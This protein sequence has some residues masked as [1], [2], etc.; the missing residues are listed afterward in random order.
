MEFQ[1]RLQCIWSFPEHAKL[2]D[3]AQP[4]SNYFWKYA[5]ATPYAQEIHA[6]KDNFTDEQR[7]GEVEKL[8]K[9]MERAA[10]LPA[11]EGTFKKVIAQGERIK[12]C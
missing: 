11:T 8:D 12:L 4:Q 9:L 5:D 7:R 2:N 1:G 6:E 3:P 10:A